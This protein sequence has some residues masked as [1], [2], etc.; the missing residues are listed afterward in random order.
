M[1]RRISAFAVTKK[2][3]EGAGEGEPDKDDPFADVDDATMA[4]VMAEMEGELGDL[5]GDEEPDPQVMAGAM[6]K[7]FK[8]T[9]KKMP[10]VMQEML[11]RMRAGEDPDELDEKY[12]DA[13]EE[14]DWGQ[15]EGANRDKLKRLAAALR[16]PK[17]DPQ[18]YEMADWV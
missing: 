16:G 11:D 13:L 5:E 9:G 8:A 4:R 17:R 6:E 15:M 3:S 7:I 18:L 1:E 10:P 14:I 12:G 2:R